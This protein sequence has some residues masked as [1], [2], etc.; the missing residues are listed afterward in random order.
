MRGAGTITTKVSVGLAFGACLATPFRR[1]QQGLECS[2]PALSQPEQTG[3]RSG[4]QGPHPDTAPHPEGRPP[5]QCGGEAET[6]G[7]FLTV[8]AAHA[9]Y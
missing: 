5:M 2:D 3:A 9:S 8:H 4:T 7:R 1:T 6:V